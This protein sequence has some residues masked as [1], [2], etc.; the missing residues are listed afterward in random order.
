MVFPTPFLCRGVAFLVWTFVNVQEALES[1]SWPSVQ[2]QLLSKKV[3]SSSMRDKDGRSTQSF[4]P[5]VHFTYLVDGKTHNG[6]RLRIPIPSYNR[7]DKAQKTLA[8]LSVTKPCEVY[9]NPANPE[10][11]VLQP[12][13]HISNIIGPTLFGL[14]L[15][16][17]GIGSFFFIPYAIRE[18][19]AKK[20][21][22]A[23]YQKEREE[24]ER[25]QKLNG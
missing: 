10:D 19:K 7:Y 9:F 3:E 20:E 5:T 25:Q 23:V 14:F 8:D 13:I 17:I 4:R 16:T 1:A 12:G 21:S 24:R 15:T 18:E 11:S 6:T 2:G 22:F